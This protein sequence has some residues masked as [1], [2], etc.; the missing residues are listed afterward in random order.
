MDEIQAAFL[1]IKLKYVDEEIVNRRAVAEYFLNNIH[2]KSIILP[3]NGDLN[4][5]VWH[6][7]VIRIKARDQLQKILLDN[8]IQTLIHYP[9]PIHKQVC[10]S[11][12]KSLNLPITE[13][14]HDEVLSLPIS[15]VM[16]NEEIVNI[17]NCLNKIT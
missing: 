11:N 8:G 17:V 4:E 16:T 7:F 15:P 10:Y 6:L 14:I 1:S 3:T 12:F 2:N 13:M 5:H 9:I